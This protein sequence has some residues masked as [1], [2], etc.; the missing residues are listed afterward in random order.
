MGPRACKWTFWMDT[1]V[2]ELS[3]PSELAN[4]LKKLCVS[5]SLQIQWFHIVTAICEEQNI[6]Q[7]SKA[8][9]S[10]DGSKSLQMDVLDGTLVCELSDPSE[11]AN[12]FKKSCTLG[13]QNP[14]KYVVK[15][16]FFITEFFFIR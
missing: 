3:D 12:G 2:C 11:L 10:S 8:F 7:V 16:I 15:T 13:S 4:G 9:A 1:L 6:R 5:M 14:L